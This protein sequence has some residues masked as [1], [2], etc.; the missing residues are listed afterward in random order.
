[1]SKL[2]VRSQLDGVLGAQAQRMTGGAT[3]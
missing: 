1:M 3:A 2:L